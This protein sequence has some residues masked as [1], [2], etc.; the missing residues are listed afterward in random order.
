MGAGIHRLRS[1]CNIDGR[2]IWSNQTC[3][4]LRISFTRNDVY[5]SATPVFLQAVLSE[6]SDAFAVRLDLLTPQLKVVV[7]AK[8]KDVFKTPMRACC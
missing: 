6:R 2:F 5:P 4:G 7:G 8:A 1:I 3:L